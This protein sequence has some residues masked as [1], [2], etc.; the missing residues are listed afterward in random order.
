MAQRR[1]REAALARAGKWIGAGC[2]R[3]TKF[4]FPLFI[5]GLEIIVTE[6]PVD[7]IIAGQIGSSALGV[8]AFNLVGVK[9][10]IVWHVARRL[11]GPMKQRAAQHIQ[12]A[13]A[14]LKSS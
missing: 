14:V 13:G 12:R 2:S 8:A 3:D 6:R 1:Q 9:F 10:E 7:D 11:A 5:V 4:P